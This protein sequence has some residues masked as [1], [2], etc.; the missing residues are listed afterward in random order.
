MKKLLAVL[1]ALIL[2]FT[3]FT[4][5]SAKPAVG[6]GPADNREVS[7]DKQGKDHLIPMN[8]DATADISNNYATSHTVTLRIDEVVRGDSALNLINTRVAKYEVMQAAPPK[9]ENN[10][11]LIAKITYTL[12]SIE[13]AEQL[14]PARIFAYSGALEGYPILISSFYN[15]TDLVELGGKELGIDETV[16]VYKVFLVNKSDSKPVMSYESKAADGS[17][18]LWFKLY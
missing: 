6:N 8:T 1:L 18:G 3:L 11:Y 10:E 17:D 15:D 14:R 9:D 2:I 12:K 7:S 13:G 4:A 5:C 16:T